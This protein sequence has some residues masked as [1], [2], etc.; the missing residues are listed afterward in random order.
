MKKLLFDTSALLATS[1]TL[2]EARLV[3]DYI[4][5]CAEVVIPQ[6]VKSEAIDLGLPGGYLDA[7]ELDRRVKEGAI[8]EDDCRGTL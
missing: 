4:L 3:L 5:A 2:V 6:G 8:A 1:K 7:Y